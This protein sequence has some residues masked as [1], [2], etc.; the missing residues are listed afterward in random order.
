M[1]IDTIIATAKKIL[2]KKGRHA[3]TLIIEDKKSWYVESLP[4]LPEEALRK[5]KLLF[6]LGTAM[7][8]E[9]DIE[10]RDVKQL[11]WIAEA[12]FTQMDKRE[13]DPAH[14]PRP[15]QM[16]NRQEGL[17]ILTLSVGEEEL[18]QDM[19]LIE[20][21][22]YG[23]TVDLLPYTPPGEHS[24]VES[25]FLLAALAGVCT[26]ALEEHKLDKMMKDLVSKD[27]YR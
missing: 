7:A 22:R 25:G 24:H 10:A 16:A 8:M 19:H 17:I 12:Y 18:Y 11:I 13:Y 5:E 9:H 15:S 21:I 3:P 4:G 2:L 20:V 14:P 23:N 26:A 6:A 1:N 27:E